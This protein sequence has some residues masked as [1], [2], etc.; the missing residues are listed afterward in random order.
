MMSKQSNT[1]NAQLNLTVN[2]FERATPTE[3]NLIIPEWDLPP[4]AS[5][6]PNGLL[7]VKK[8]V[9]NP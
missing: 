8:S 9:K 3:W 4:M 2:K 5:R 1:G 7:K 6:L